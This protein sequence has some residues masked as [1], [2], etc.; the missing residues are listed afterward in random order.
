M[1]TEKINGRSN[2]R[3]LIILLGLA[4]AIGIGYRYYD[5]EIE[6]VDLNGCSASSSVTFNNADD[7]RLNAVS[8][9]AI[10]VRGK[11]EF[12]FTAPEINIDRCLLLTPVYPDPSKPTV[13]MI[14][15]K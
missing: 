10:E 1:N 14:P 12:V 7:T 2:L 11:E 15:L 4:A 13:T 3:G 6:T 5:R 9:R 8:T